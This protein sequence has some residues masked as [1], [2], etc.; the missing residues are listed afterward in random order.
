[1]SKSPKLQTSSVLPTPKVYGYFKGS[2]TPGQSALKLQ[3]H[4]NT[5]QNDLNN[6]HGGGKSMRVIVPQPSTH[7]M[8]QVSPNNGNSN[9]VK[10]AS[11]LLQN[12]ANAEFD[13]QVGKNVSQTGGKKRKSNKRKSNKRKTKKRK[14]KKR[15]SN[16]R[17]SNKRKSNKRKTKKRK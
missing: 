8:N 5:Q 11:T 16:K 10:G 4:E 2:Q 7:G 14:S 6:T 1:M 9:T 3:A 15:K 13:N 12:H 17:K